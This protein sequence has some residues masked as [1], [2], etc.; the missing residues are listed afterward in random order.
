MLLLWNLRCSMFTAPVFFRFDLFIACIVSSF[1]ASW[2]SV[3]SLMCVLNSSSIDFLDCTSSKYYFHNLC[4]ITILCHFPLF[5]FYIVYSHFFYAILI[6]N[7]IIGIGVPHISCFFHSSFTLLIICK[8]SNIYLRL[9]QCLFVLIWYLL[10]QFPYLRL[11]L[12]NFQY[13]STFLIS[14]M[15]SLNFTSQSNFRL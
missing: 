11:I 1:V 14:S 15:F 6:F 12:H 7:W 2:I 8:Y 10:H 3:S 9:P 13:Y 4:L 5:V